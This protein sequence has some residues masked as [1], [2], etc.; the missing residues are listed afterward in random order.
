MTQQTINIGTTPN[1]GQGDP[2]RVAFEKINQNFSELYNLAG[3]TAAPPDSSVQFRSTNNLSAIARSNGIWVVFGSPNRY[4]R[5]TDGVLWSDESAPV[6]VTI[7]D[8]VATPTGFIAVGDNGTVITS[9]DNGVTWA[10]RPS[11]TTHNLHAVHYEQSTGRY[12]AAGANGVAIVSDN[13]ETWELR[14]TGTTETLYAIA[15][16]PVGVGYVVVGDVGTVILSLDGAVWTQQASG[17]TERLSGVTYDG[18]SYIAVGH[19]GI[20]ITSTNAVNWVTRTSGTV[21]NLRSIATG[22]VA[23]TAVSVTVGANGVTRYSADGAGVTWL[24]ISTGTTSELNDVTW[25]GVSFYSTGAN[26]TILTTANTTAWSNVSVSGSFTGSANFTFDS[27]TDTLHVTNLDAEQITITDVV[28]NVVAANQIVAYNLANLGCVQ[29][30]KI[31]GG[32]SG[33]Y[34]QTDGQGNLSWGSGDSLGPAAPNNSVQFNNDGQ[35]GGTANFTWDNANS[36]LEITGNLVSTQLYVTDYSVGNTIA[37]YRVT[38]I[39]TAVP[40]YVAN[41]EVYLLP[42]NQQGLFVLPIT[43]D[44][45]YVIDGILYQID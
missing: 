18:A 25:T 43:V 2:L 13:P 15:N 45:V 6:S 37:S 36:N 21:E 41:S 39:G 9:A 40:Y 20:V 31:F 12:M 34:L 30:V 3:N 23:N 38:N 22:N 27:T 28:A 16:N 8:V 24:S 19:S 32:N 42:E 14:S 33:Q 35:F 10:V 5:S 11:G 1:D 17:T 26:G 44:G 29:N 7:N 4:Y